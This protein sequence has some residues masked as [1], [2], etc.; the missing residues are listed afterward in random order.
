MPWGHSHRKVVAIDSFAHRRPP[1]SWEQTVRETLTVLE[2]AAS[3][4]T[5]SR[6]PRL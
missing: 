6:G 4:W 5:R 3:I 1:F 2:E